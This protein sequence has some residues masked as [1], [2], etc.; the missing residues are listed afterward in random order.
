MQK[1]SVA[2]IGGGLA[3]LTAALALAER[4][5]T[6]T[7]FEASAQLGGRARTVAIDQLHQTHLLDN[8]QHILLGVYEKTLSILIKK[9]HSD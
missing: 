2:I 5:I 9:W 8:G 3:G 4:G 6:V 7:I 1:T